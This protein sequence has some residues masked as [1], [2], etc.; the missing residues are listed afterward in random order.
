MSPKEI[1]QKKSE[2]IEDILSPSTSI[3]LKMASL[4]ALWTLAKMEA[5]NQL[6]EEKKKLS[7]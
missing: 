5:M 7:Y 3:Q 6:E 1:E 4:D 2:L